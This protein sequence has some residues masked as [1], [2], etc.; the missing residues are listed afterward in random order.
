MHYNIEN[1]NKTLKIFSYDLA[2][3]LLE[4]GKPPVFLCVGNSKVVD[5]SL[6]AIVGT[7]LKDYYKIKF[8]ILGNFN[9]PLFGESLTQSL[10]LLITKYFNNTIIVIDASIGNLNNL[11]NVNLTPHGIN[12]NC[13]KSQKIVG[14][15]SI[16]SITN[17]G[18]FT[19]LLLLNCEKKKHIFDVA[20]FIACGIYNSLNI[21]KN[22]TKINVI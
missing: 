12:I 7:L 11:Y 21:Y 4:K 18:K 9:N 1:K 22:T 15:I 6:G 2:N 5:D 3:S 14:D 20:N 10:E 8:P 19:N 13:F 16:T 17:V